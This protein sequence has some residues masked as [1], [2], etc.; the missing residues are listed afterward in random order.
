MATLKRLH[1]AQP[2]YYSKPFVLVPKSA[3]LCSAEH[4]MDVSR[5]RPPEPVPGTL[6]FTSHIPIV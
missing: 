6:V 1:A 2:V 3:L 5:W 4:Q